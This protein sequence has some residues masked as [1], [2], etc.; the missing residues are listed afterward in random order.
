MIKRKSPLL[1]AFGALVLVACGSSSLT[2]SSS[3]SSSLPPSS[4]SVSSEDPNPDLPLANGLYNYTAA[5][6]DDKAEILGQ[7]EKWAQDEFLAGI[8]MYDSGGNVLYNGRLTIPSDVFIPNYGFGVGEGTINYPM[9][10][11]QEPNAAY[12]SYFHTW[13][14]NEPTTLNYMDAQDSVTADFYGL[15]NSAYYGTKFTEDKTAYEWYPSLA[16]GFPVALNLNATTGMATRWRVPVRTDAAMVYSTLSTDPTIAAFNGRRVALEDYLTPFQLMLDN[17]WFRATDL[18]SATTGFKGVGAYSRNVAAGRPADWASVGIQLNVAEN[19]IDFE[20]NVPKTAFYAM[21]NLSTTLFSPI[22][23]DFIDAIGGPTEFGKKNIDSVLSLGIYT[24]EEW[25]SNLQAVF[26]KNTAFFEASRYNY[27]GYKYKFIA[28]TTA[29]LIAFDE[30]LSG[31]L[32]AVGVPSARINEFKSDPRRRVTF[33]DTVFKLQTNATTQ[34]RWEELFGEDGSIVQTAPANY[35][36]VKPVMSNKNFLNGLYFAIDRISLADQLGRNPAQAFLSDAYMIDP[37]TGVSYRSSDAGKAAIADRLPETAGYSEELAKALFVEAM[38]EEVAAGNYV[39][40]TTASPTVIT[41]KI[42]WQTAVSATTD[43]AIIKSFFEDTFNEAV[44]GFQ[45][46]IDNFATANWYDVYYDSMMTG[47]FDFAMGAIS[48][49]TLDPLN[50]MEVLISDN[51]SGFTLS[52]GADTGAATQAIRY[53]GHAWSYN[54]LFS[55]ANGGTVAEDGEPA[56]LLTLGTR[57]EDADLVYA[58]ELYPELDEVTGTYDVNLVGTYFNEMPNDVVIDFF[59]VSIY[60]YWNEVYVAD[61]DAAD[62]IVKNNDGTFTVTLEDLDIPWSN[63]YPEDYYGF[64]CEVAYTVTIQGVTT[65]FV[66]SVWFYSPVA[67]V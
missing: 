67:P 9:T 19:A 62:V 6:Y 46:V 3:S 36:D 58:G 7:L 18:G 61:F 24:L 10:A 15:F 5:D 53:D 59:G 65:P 64:I 45:L 43:G 56:V 17:Q 1:L 52:W 66:A 29:S 37:E 33:G 51:R 22:P 63:P 42:H 12:R 48:G 38:N 44:E 47:Q 54:A 16:T 27:A 35:W 2:P 14:Q 55:A 8:P 20:F 25:Q 40:G 32:D 4:T 26:K 31:N 23:E 60:D 50:F 11:A 13:T 21:Y 57:P 34:E 30:F 41:L 39:R 49:N 28:G